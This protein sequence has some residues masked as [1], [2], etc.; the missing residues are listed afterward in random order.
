M[1]DCPNAGMRDLLPDFV[2]GSLDGE[3]RAEVEAHVAT[4]A[5]CA[6]EVGLLRA[7][8]AALSRPLALDSARIAG[9]IPPAIRA[10]GRFSLPTAWRRAAVIVVA[11]L[12]GLSLLT[13]RDGVPRGARVEQQ[14]TAQAVTPGL[15]LGSGMAE[16]SSAEMEL[17]LG[18]LHTLDGVIAEEPVEP[19]PAIEL[20][21]G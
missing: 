16:L 20:G 21:D 11:A 4:C 19:L 15:S 7:V 6:G 14:R 9:A 17:L 3:R 13:L 18:E 2:H 10:P 5:S 1:T 8:R 12:G